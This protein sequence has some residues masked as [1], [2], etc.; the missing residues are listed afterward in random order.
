MIRK[1]KIKPKE[2]FND[3]ETDVDSRVGWGPDG[4]N[5]EHLI[6]FTSP[7]PMAITAGPDHLLRYVNPA[8]CQLLSRTKDEL[9]GRRFG[10]I[11]PWEGCLALLNRVYNTGEI[12]IQTE[13]ERIGAHPD[14]WSYT[15][16]P[17]R[18]PDRQPAGVIV[19]VAEI[20]LFHQRTIAV[21]Q[22]LLLSGG[23]RT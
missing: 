18:G 13:P 16:W 17:V 20:T 9:T 21:N 2:V 19:L 4:S 8:F 14:R 12:A 3:P 11:A 6:V 7:L 10:E 23:A 1:S 22:Q 15:M 5:S